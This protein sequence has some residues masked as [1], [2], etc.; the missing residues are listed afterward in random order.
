MRIFLA[1]I[2]LCFSLQSLTKADDIRDFQIEGMS[3]GD[4]ALDFFAETTI[5]SGLNVS[6]NDD[7]FYGREI[8][9]DSDTYE[10]ISLTFKKNDEK[11]IIYQIKGMVYLNFDKCLKK[12]EIVI[13]QIKEIL[14]N[15]I[16]NSYRGQ[17]DKAYGE[18]FAEVTDL[19]IN[20][21]F[22]RVWC[23]T[24]D[25]NFERTKNWKDTLSVDASSEEYGEWLNNKAY[26]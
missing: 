6:Y 18:S 1:I 8:K 12:K 4:S 19:K 2:I 20:G 10:S 25:K 16:E 15:Q 24:F 14:Q 13:S 3:I 7:S 9:I 26:K 11:F 23:D 21:G 5:M 22:I 17:Y